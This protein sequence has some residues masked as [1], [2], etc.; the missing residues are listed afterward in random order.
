MHT[1]DYIQTEDRI[2]IRYGFSLSDKKTGRG[3]ILFLN[4]RSEFL[5]KHRETVGELLD[6]GY[7]VFAFDW[8]GQG[9]S[10]RLIE[11]PYKGYVTDYADYVRDMNR[12]V[13]EVVL[14]RASRP[15]SI[16][17][18]S[19]GGHIAIRYLHDYPEIF[20]RA[21]FLS[22]MAA[23]CTLPYPEWFARG[24]AKLAVRLG[25]SKSYAIGCGDYRASD[26]KSFKHNKLTSD[27]RRFTDE[28]VEIDKNPN[29]ALGGVTY[30]WLSA[31]FDSTDMIFQPGYLEEIEIPV[32]MISAPN[33]RVVCVPSQ[34]RLCHR[35]ANCRRIYISDSRH[36]ILKECDRIREKFWM[37][38]EEFMSDPDAFGLTFGQ[39]M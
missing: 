16:L 21:V 14:P 15:L 2:R 23:I 13:H 20:D 30:Q 12:I 1:I 5:E 24:L 28:R 37:I 25:H 31:T 19:M 27:F 18:H 34:K 36:E 29:L 17:S 22:P 10:S 35:M 32:L 9:L 11:H 38:F 26:K 6:R 8:R 33:D 7:D 3:S 4:G 39:Q